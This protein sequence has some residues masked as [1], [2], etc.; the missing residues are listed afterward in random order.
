MNV[1]FKFIKSVYCEPDEVE[2]ESKEVQMEVSSTAIEVTTET[3]IT[4]MKRSESSDTLR[5]TEE[6]TSIT[7]SSRDLDAD[8]EG[9][10]LPVSGLSS[11]NQLKLW[12]FY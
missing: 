11:Y 9:V 2:A 7:V 6:H 4:E 3:T 1:Y 8:L 12:N 5:F 10:E